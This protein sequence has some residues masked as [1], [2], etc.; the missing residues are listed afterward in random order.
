MIFLQLRRINSANKYDQITLDGFSDIHNARRPL[1]S[2]GKTFERIIK[3]IELYFNRTINNSLYISIRVNVDNNNLKDY[4]S[5]YS[6]LKE[7]FPFDN[8]DVYPGWVTIKEG[9]KGFSSC[10]SINKQNDFCLSLAEKG[11]KY[12]DIFPKFVTLCSVTN[13]YSM[14]IGP[15]GNIYKCWE[16]LGIEGKI[17]GNIN[18][19]MV[20]KNLELRAKYSCGVNRFNDPIC[21]Q[22]EYL[23]ICNGGCP[24]RRFENKYEGS[25][26][27]YCT[28]FKGRLKEYVLMHYKEKISQHTNI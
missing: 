17:V 4:L 27:N 15:D 14:L 13:P 23:P 21:R 22:C 12:Q 1:K 3:N 5:L 8:F 18:T 16:D 7:K 9:G 19:Q 2:G 11:I 26:N 28:Y 24:I 20:W 6:F 10:V 25:H